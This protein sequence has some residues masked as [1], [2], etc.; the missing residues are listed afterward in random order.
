[1]G[2]LTGTAWWVDAHL[3]HYCALGAFFMGLFFYGFFTA[4]TDLYHQ[5]ERLQRRNTELMKIRGFYDQE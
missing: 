2:V 4:S 3:V 1:M 5:A